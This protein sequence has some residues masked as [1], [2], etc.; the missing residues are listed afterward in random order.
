MAA[1][2]PALSN[3][4]TD[5][6]TTTLH[7]DTPPK[8]LRG[9]NKPKCIQCGN[10]ARSR[11]PYQS[12]KSC[13]SK[14]QNPCHIHVL[15]AATF[16]DKTPTSST[17]STEQKSTDASPAGTSL[18]VASL[19][20]LSNNFAQFNNVQMPLRSRKPLTRKDAAAINEWR[21]S[22]LKEYRD[23]NVE[24][25]NEAFDRYMQ[26]ICLLE[27]VFSVKSILDGSNEDESSMANPASNSVEEESEMMISGPKLKLR[28]NPIRSENSRKRMQQLI[29]RGLK[30][31]QSELNDEDNDINDQNESEKSPKKAKFWWSERASALNDIIDKLNKARTDEDPKSYTKL[32]S[33]L[34]NLHIQSIDTETQKDMVSEEQTE[35]NDVPSRK[36]SGYVLPKLLTT[37]EIDQETLSSID[38]H[39]SSLEKIEDL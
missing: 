6:P 7:R 32:K 38:A 18:R 27:E 9:L 22:K 30:K 35:K 19:R 26:N 14:A 31:L 16:P 10:V 34:R 13:C 3:N 1:S 28:S 8:T 24:A 21:F 25:E 2:S 23:R 29:D 15:K 4:A 20:Q 37:T 5:S 39:F 12:C 11:C 17:P 33:Q 36:E